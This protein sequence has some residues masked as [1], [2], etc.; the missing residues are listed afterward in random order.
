MAAAYRAKNYGRCVA[1]ASRLEASGRLD[2]RSALQKGWCL[3]ALNRPQEAALAFGR[4]AAAAA[5]WLMRPMAR[6]WRDCAAASPAEAAMAANSAALAPQKR[7]EIGV[8]VLAQQAASS[9]D[10][11][12]YRATLESSNQRRMYTQEPRDL[13][14]L[15]A[16]SLYHLGYRE[17]AQQVFA[18]LD[19]Q[20]STKDTRA[21]LAVTS[22]RKALR[23]D[24]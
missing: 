12:R 8:G 10:A 20:L 9:F 6:R 3:M 15:R 17:E 18:T 5:R 23:E 13:S 19:Q 22:Q 21:G 2:P 4:R 1:L 7:N 14:V 24:K 16:W 11:E